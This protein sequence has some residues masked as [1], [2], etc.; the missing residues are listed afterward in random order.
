M[1]L[2]PTE[3]KNEKVTVLGLTF[4]SEDERREY[5]R[6]ELR[7]KLPEL[8]NMEGFPIGEDDDI[9]NLSD[10]PYYTACP[11]PWL[12]DFIAEWESKK[13]ELQK[14][15]KRFI[16]KYVTKPF[17]ADVTEG[18]NNAVYS[19]H[20]YH[21]KVPHPAI[22]RY[23]LHYSQPG[24][25]VM[26]GF[27]GTGMTGVAGQLCSNPDNKLKNRINQEFKDNNLNLPNW[28]E[29]KVICSDL[30]TIATYLAFSY[31]SNIDL[32]GLKQQVNDIS[33]KVESECKWMYETKHFDEHTKGMVNYMVWSD[34]Y[35]CSQCHCE[36]VFWEYSI[37][38]E[39]AEV[40]D[41]VICKKCGSI[42]KIKKLDRVFK[43][44]FDPITKQTR[45]KALQVPVLKY[46]EVKGKKYV[47]NVSEYDRELIAKIE[48][49]EIQ[50]SI[51]AVQLPKGYNTRQPMRSHGY[52]Y[53]HDF[54]SKRNAITLNKFFEEIKSSGNLNL[55][56]IL[57]GM[58]V[59]STMM[60]RIHLKNFVFGGGGWNAGHR[61]GTLYMP[62]ISIE[63]S[64]LVQ[65]KHKL[66]S[67]LRAFKITKD[68]RS[69]IS[70]NSAT[71][72]PL[73]DNSIDFMYVDPPFG[74]NINYSELNIFWESALGVLTNNQK[75]AIEN[76]VQ[77][78]SLFDYQVLMEESFKEF[79]RVL[80]P[81]KWVVVEFSN[82][83]A[84][85]WNCIS[86]SISISGFVISTVTA[87][88]KKQGGMSSIV[89]PTAVKQDL[90]IS[91][92]KPSSEFTEKLNFENTDVAVWDFL[93]EHLN[94]LPIHLI[95]GN[96][97]NYIIERSP[98]ILYDRLISFYVQ[99]GFPVPIDA[100]K[101]QKGLREHFIERDGMFFTTEQAQ[102]YDQKK[103]DHPEFIQ[104]SLLVSSEKDGILW[105][106][107]LLSDKK[108]TY[109]DIQPEWMQALAGVRKGDV[110]P[111]LMNIL[112]ENFLKD[113]EGKWYLP[114]PEN[115]ADLEKL[116]NKRL[117]R[118]FDHYKE[119][120]AKSKGRIKE[121][122]VEALRAGFKQCYQ[123]KDFKTIIQVGDRIPSNLL[124]EDEVLLQFYDIASTRV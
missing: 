78:K 112:E 95:K 46:Y 20:S 93:M 114:D 72:I 30:S 56:F 9:I 122:R 6:E 51:K 87:L 48:S 77:N 81:G 53:V 108:L 66:K 110:I 34:V 109:Q 15:G 25:I 40:I 55:L 58:I 118:Q 123:E 23:I 14:N 100:A 111:E 16:D 13:T 98:K 47:D 67:A 117:L 38:T 97:S 80:K 27:C 74:A 91:C 28:G 50:H 64:P 5:F 63:T 94:H 36:L 57:T 113:E 22:M 39:T 79:Y 19:A 33:L 43:T 121:V 35:S 86:T 75:E 11:N 92:Y 12:N 52:E 116:R 62:S 2:F 45:K 68:F 60:N 115:E 70:V 29:R 42:L 124:M 107:H 24:D 76:S 37:N 1:S 102:E 84:S 18:K 83:K 4:N 105:L 3:N 104:L 73:K 96:A 17:T 90:V 32:E 41:E 85:V 88:D 82:T 69:I 21:T 59:R 26:D 31:N 101:F 54:Y 120:A 89:S 8:K 65:I 71:R 10:P 61:K 119:Q 49:E 99:K 103:K 7:K 44:F 106:Q